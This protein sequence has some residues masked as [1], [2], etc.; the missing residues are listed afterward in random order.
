MFQ[1]GCMSEEENKESGSGSPP[2]GI[3]PGAWLPP[4]L[5][6]RLEGADLPPPNKGKVDLSGW[7]AMLVVVGLA[8]GVFWW[9]GQRK[10]AAKRVEEARREQ[11]RLAA[12][13]E[14]LAAVRTADSLR[15]VARADSARAFLALPAWKQAEILAGKPGGD[16]ATGTNLDEAGKFTIDAGTF[17]FEEPAQEAANAIQASSNLKARVVPV[18][19]DGSTSYHVYVGDFSQR[20]AAAFAADRLLERGTAATARVVKLD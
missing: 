20:G 14:S 15:T 13:A 11:V 5:R 10:Q 8:A 9:A 4:R 7:I 3:P 6:D 17:L 16:A 2:A 12:V 19:A 1:E 18:E